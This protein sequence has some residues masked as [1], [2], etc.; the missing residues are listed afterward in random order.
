MRF[1]PVSLAS[2][3]A[4]Q[5]PQCFGVYSVFVD[6]LNPCGSWLASDGASS[7]TADLKIF[8]TVFDGESS[9]CEQ[10]QSLWE[11]ACQR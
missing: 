8:P 10:P 5:R 2:S 9:I 1:V 11:L 7:N 3:L 4:S 6:N